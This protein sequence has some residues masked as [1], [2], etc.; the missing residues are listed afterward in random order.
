MQII[1][2]CAIGGIVGF[3]LA[4][5]AIVSESMRRVKNLPLLID[6]KEIFGKKLTHE[7][8]FAV[9]L[10]LHLILSTLMGGIYTLFAPRSLLIFSLFAWVAIGALI[11][12]ALHLGFF[13]RHEG[14][15]V[16]FELLVLQLLTAFGLWIGFSYYQPFFFG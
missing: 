16:W 14:P 9:S 8:L 10:L 1:L 13:G 2:G 7:E 6:V 15:H 5:P 4:L 3:L 11:F 12:P